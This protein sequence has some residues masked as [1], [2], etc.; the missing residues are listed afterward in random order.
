MS[1]MPTL[2]IPH[3]GGPC[4]FMD[5]DPPDTWERMAAY[6]L[7]VPADIGHR[8]E[9]IV[10]ISA[11]WEEEIVTIQNNPAP[12]L[13]F[14]YY[15]FPEDTYRIEYPAPGS[16]EHATRISMLLGQAGIA[17]RFDSERGFDHGVFI[18]LKIALPRAD[19]PIV[20]VSLRSDL[21]PSAHIELGKALR[22]LRD[23]GVLIMGSGMTHHNLQT[24][25]K[26]MRGSNS[27]T[28]ASERFDEWL[29]DVLTR[30]TPETRERSLAVWDT[31]PDARRAHP[32]E[33]HLLPLH[34]I[35]GAAGPDKGHRMLK[36]S[37]LGTVQSA[38]QFG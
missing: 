34:V 21:D 25:M 13:V 33:E 32:R 4:F 15:G 35:V 31:A 7:G 3:G 14:D 28:P 12:A 22:P 11:H 26:N 16:P 27:T 37:V 30:A 36:D 19:I 6:L 17:S 5:W 8:P 10:L 24:M 1:T 29:T 20:Q 38:F 2:F 23:E 9:A 18:P